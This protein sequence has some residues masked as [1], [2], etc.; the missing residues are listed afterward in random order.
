MPDDAEDEKEPT[1]PSPGFTWIGERSTVSVRE[2][3]G[4]WVVFVRTEG[5]GGVDG[6]FEV[7]E[8]RIRDYPTRRAA[9]IA[10][11]W[12]E[13]TAN[14]GMERPNFGNGPVDASAR[15]SL[16]LPL[17]TA[18]SR[19]QPIG[20]FPQPASFLALPMAGLTPADR[21]FLM[22]G[23]LPEP[24]P[25]TLIF[26]L[27]ALEGDVNAALAAL[28]ENDDLSRYNRF[29]LTRDPA[30]YATL[31]AEFSGDLRALLDLTANAFAIPGAGRP[32]PATLDGELRAAALGALARRQ[33]AADDPTAALA[34][35]A[36]AA[37]AAREESPVLAAQLLASRA[38]LLLQGDGFSFAVSGAYTAALAVLEPHPLAAEFRA[39]LAQTFAQLTQQH[40]EG[41]RNRLADAVQ[42][43]GDALRVFRR[44]TH[45]EAF[46]EAQVGLA[47]CYLQLPMREASDQLRTGI[48]VQALR[49]ALEVYTPETHPEEWASAQLN[50]ANALLY[51]PTTHPRENIA[52]A[53]GLYEE[54]LA[55]RT[56]EGDPLGHARALTNQGNAL[57]HAGLFDHAH[58][59]LDT[60]LALFREHGDQEGMGTALELLG[61]VE[62]RVGKSVI[63][64]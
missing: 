10:A 22:V 38:N 27:R 59:N 48:A 47:L 50:L 60:A 30:L 49:E 55:V 19:P 15:D 18:L 28:G 32:D 4:R 23:R 46:A 45:P 12:I 51:A 26:L 40:A 36:E 34:T 39:S 33:R 21:A 13:R 43:Y 41:R 57:A 14:R 24:L 37:E 53:I 54:V 3:H 64:R 7:F 58:R 17:M 63:E 35:L 31:A 56:R 62:P 20:L 29:A 16:P 42:L 11:S 61:Q 44:E 9:D 1:V 2:E 25:A 8:A 6:P 52:Q 5:W